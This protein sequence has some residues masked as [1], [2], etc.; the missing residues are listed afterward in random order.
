MATIKELFEDIDVLHSML[1]N[2]DRSASEILGDIRKIGAK[3]EMMVFDLRVMMVELGSKHARFEECDKI[4]CDLQ[5]KMDG[6]KNN[7][8]DKAHKV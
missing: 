3:I 6:L 7:P 2:S 8:N 1:Y 4:L 5:G